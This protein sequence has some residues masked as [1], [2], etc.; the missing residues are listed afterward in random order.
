MLNQYEPDFVQMLKP[1]LRWHDLWLG[2]EVPSHNNWSCFK[3]LF[4]FLFFA[5]SLPHYRHMIVSENEGCFTY[6]QIRS[7]LS[8]YYWYEIKFVIPTGMFISWNYDEVTG[9]CFFMVNMK[10]K[11]C[12]FRAMT[13]KVYVLV[14][15][16]T[17]DRCSSYLQMAKKRIFVHLFFLRGVE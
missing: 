7:Q 6:R 2:E 17:L 14:P 8:C 10:S 4:T 13:W 1:V 5:V 16:S 12:D 9:I 15:I 11:W 3:K